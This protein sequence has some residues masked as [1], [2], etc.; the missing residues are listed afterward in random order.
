MLSDAGRKSCP[1][2]VV[3]VNGE[4]EDLP[5]D[6]ANVLP[7]GLD[8]LGLEEVADPRP[9]PPR[10]PKLR[11]ASAEGD[12]SSISSSSDERLLG[13][14]S[15]LV[16]EITADSVGPGTILGMDGGLE[17]KL[18]LV[19]GSNAVLLSVVDTPVEVALRET[20]APV[21]SDATTSD[22]D[23]FLFRAG[24]DSLRGVGIDGI[25][26]DTLP[27]GTVGEIFDI[28]F[29]GGGMEETEDETSEVFAADTCMVDKGDAA[30]E[31]A[32]DMI[33]NEDDCDAGENA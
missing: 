20:G 26:L 29:C 27:S 8:F 24:D 17:G 5:S 13:L 19:T 9:N 31:E 6:V 32:P 4:P 18:L 33:E 10:A 12:S 3:K 14:A 16:R 21:T 28:D 25:E 1:G 23:T 15:F 2:L 30:K 7:K 22:L 11:S